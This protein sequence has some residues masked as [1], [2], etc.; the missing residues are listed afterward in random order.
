MEWNID[1]I[2]QIDPTYDDV[3]GGAL[4]IVTDPR[5]WGAVGYFDAPG[6]GKIYYRVEFANAIRVGSVHWNQQEN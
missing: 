5:R 2:V 6:Q 3:F 1:D 4:M